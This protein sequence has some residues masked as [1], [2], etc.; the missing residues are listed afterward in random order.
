M[1]RYALLCVFFSFATI[2]MWKRELVGLLFFLF[3]AS[4][5]C[6]KAFPYGAVGLSAVCD[7]GIF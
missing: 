2:L 5:Y 6:Y 4:C 7:C 1:F 3:L